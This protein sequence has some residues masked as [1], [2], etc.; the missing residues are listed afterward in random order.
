MALGGSRMEQRLDLNVGALTR[1]APGITAPLTPRFAESG[2][3]SRRAN[4]ANIAM[5]NKLAIAKLKPH[6]R[7]SFSTACLILSTAVDLTSMNTRCMYP[8]APLYITIVKA[9]PW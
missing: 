8:V 4:R 1:V 6:S 7:R 2:N 9:F 5:V 3:L